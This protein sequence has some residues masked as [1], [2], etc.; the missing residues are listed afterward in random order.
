MTKIFVM[1]VKGLN[2]VNTPNT[3]NYQ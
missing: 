2:L 3:V 1:S